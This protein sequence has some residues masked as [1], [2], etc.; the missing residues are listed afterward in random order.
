MA[1]G[2]NSYFY[3]LLQGRSRRA[4]R[5]LQ[6]S[7]LVRLKESV[8]SYCNRVAES[9]RS[10]QRRSPTQIVSVGCDAGSAASH[11]L[12]LTQ[13]GDAI[14]RIR[15]ALLQ[16]WARQPR[17]SAKAVLTGGTGEDAK[18]H[19]PVVAIARRAVALSVTIRHCCSALG[20]RGSVQAI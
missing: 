8:R 14:A 20:L 6:A 9:R 2:V 12:A 11:P 19:D 13:R 16:V 15:G 1:V 10:V 4:A 7:M 18:V 5:S 17:P 3:G